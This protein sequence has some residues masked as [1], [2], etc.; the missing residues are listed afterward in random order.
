LPADPDLESI[1]QEPGERRRVARQPGR[2]QQPAG[3]LDP[4]IVGR[5]ELVHGHRELDVRAV[6]AH[7]HVAERRGMRERRRRGRH[8]QTHKCQDSSHGEMK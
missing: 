8:R 7:V 4:E 1:L 3:I 2:I 6:H 5:V